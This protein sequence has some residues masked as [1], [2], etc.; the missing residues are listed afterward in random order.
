M[1]DSL[2]PE[3][4]ELLVS[5]IDSM[6]DL[7]SLRLVCQRL[8]Q[9]TYGTFIRAGFQT[10]TTA[11]CPSGLSRLRGI[12]SCDNLRLAV[13]SIHTANCHKCIP[14]GMHG[15]GI[16]APSSP[17]QE[18]LGSW[19]DATGFPE[20]VARFINCTTLMIGGESTR[21]FCI[22]NIADRLRGE[23]TPFEVLKLFQHALDIEN[24]PRIEYLLL[25][26]NPNSLQPW[27]RD[28]RVHTIR[29][30]SSQASL[31]SVRHLHLSWARNMVDIQ[32]VLSLVLSLTNLTKFELNLVHFRFGNIFLE[33]L[34]SSP[35][36]PPIADL[37]LYNMDVDPS[38]ILSDV[39]IRFKET[40]RSLY[41]ASIELCV[42]DWNTIFNR[43]GRR[44][45]PCLESITAFQLKASIVPIYWQSYHQVV[46]CP[47]FWKLEALGACGGGT[48]EFAIREF[49]SRR[50]AVGIRFRGSRDQ[51]SRFLRVLA[52]DPTTTVEDEPGTQTLGLPDMTVSLSSEDLHQ[53]WREV[54]PREL[55]ID[56]ADESVEFV[57]I[58]A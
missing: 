29:S 8:Y 51:T 43:I 27:G 34:I 3:L 22:T 11:F 21:W 15:P 5:F 18:D 49:L 41:L 14:G 57:E 33:E 58:D 23:F 24:G 26:L 48:F 16:F 37:R 55:L 6:T 47:L 12:A 32:P 20:L 7:Q 19:E 1:L 52:D 53:V 10:L 46:F 39:I 42:G 31:A 4:V 35:S 17:S 25:D 28:L 54:S 56:G 30:P 50:R 38:S 36:V 45:F 2:S 44:E 9:F 13:R 40:L